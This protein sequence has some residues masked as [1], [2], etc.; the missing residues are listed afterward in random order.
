M[1]KPRYLLNYDALQ[2]VLESQPPQVVKWLHN[3]ANAF[4]CSG[5]SAESKVVCINDGSVHYETV[6]PPLGYATSR[7]GVQYLPQFFATRHAVLHAPE[8]MCVSLAN[9]AH[10][11]EPLFVTGG[12]IQVI[13]VD[14]GLFSGGAKALTELLTTILADF[15]TVLRADAVFVVLIL[16]TYFVLRKYTKKNLF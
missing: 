8:P 1:Q 7:Q 5:A 12:K 2:V 13:F 16:F 10:K 15:K 9:I 3:L 6:S 4:V 11:V 14:W